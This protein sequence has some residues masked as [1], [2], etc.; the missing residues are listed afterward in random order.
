[1]YHKHLKGR[2]F[3]FNKSLESFYDTKK[4]KFPPLPGKFLIDSEALSCLVVL[5]FINDGN[6][7]Q[8]KLHKVLRHMF[9]HRE[10]RKWI[11]S[12]LLEIIN[13]AHEASLTDINSP[14]PQV[15]SFSFETF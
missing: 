11:T 5:L 6:I 2:V 15:C 10:G 14:Q 13:K 4:N 8:S 9:I 12:T 3:S 7:Q 1:M